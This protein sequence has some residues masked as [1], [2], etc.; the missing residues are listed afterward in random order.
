M[1]TRQEKDP[2]SVVQHAATLSTAG[3]RMDPAQLTD[4][5]GY[6][7]TLAPPS[8][9]PAAF[10]PL[11]SRAS[12]GDRQGMGDRQ[13]APN[14]AVAKAGTAL[15][16]AATQAGFKPLAEALW[17][18]L[19]IEDPKTLATALQTV[20]KQFPDLAK[21]VL[22][23]DANTK[24]LADILSASAANGLAAAGRGV[25]QDARKVPA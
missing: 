17:P 25:P 13:V 14:D 6:R 22:A 16:A 24:V 23:S 18:L 12:T 19:E 15:Y 9:P 2:G 4:L 3:Y 11:R 8:L 21:K 7:V 1:D 10:A 5:S 20:L